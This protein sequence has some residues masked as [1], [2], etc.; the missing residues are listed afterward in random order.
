MVYTKLNELSK[1]LKSNF[2]FNYDTSALTWFRA[3]GFVD[4]F[5]LVA[6]ENELEIILSRIGNIPYEIIGAGSN[7]LIRDKGFKILDIDF[8]QFIVKRV[9]QPE[10]L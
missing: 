2:L 4:I 8:P 1:N 7:I 9:M 6:D 5:C 10:I 3:G